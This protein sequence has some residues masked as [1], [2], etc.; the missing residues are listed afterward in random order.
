[1][2]GPPAPPTTPRLTR[3]YVAVSLLCVVA[4]QVYLVVLAFRLVPDFAV[5]FEGLGVAVPWATRLF[6][7]LYQFSPLMPVVCG[8][9]TLV[10]V[11]KDPIP[12]ASAVTL[13][14]VS[15]ALA[16][17]FQFW[18]VEAMFSPMI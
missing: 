2:N 12:F 13:F 10:V 4:W 5:L 6:L 7:G 9:I 16:L 3:A 8:M 18:F 14:A 11:R 17:G 1:M 15:A